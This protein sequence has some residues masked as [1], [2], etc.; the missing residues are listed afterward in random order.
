MTGSARYPDV[1]VVAPP[2]TPN[3][4]LHVGHLAGPYLGADVFTRFERIRGRD[5]VTALSTDEHQSYV[6]TTAA[7]LGRAPKDLAAAS[8]A[9]VQRTLT[10]AG[11]TFDIVGRPDDAYADDVTQWLQRLLEVGVFVERETDSLFDPATGRQLVESY[12]GGRCP[13]CLQATRGNICESC[14]HPNDPVRLV[15]PS[16]DCT[17]HQPER[18][19][20]RALVLPLERYRARL[21]EHYRGRRTRPELA[22]LLDRLLSEPLPPFPVAYE[23]SWGL[24]VPGASTV[25][26]VWAEMYPGHL[27]WIERARAHTSTQSPAPAL[28]ETGSAPEYVQFIGFDNSFFYAVV[29]VALGMAARDA[30]LPAAPPPTIITNQFYLLDGAKFST[31]QGHVIWGSALLEEWEPD[32]VRLFLCLSSPETQESNFT[33]EAM[34]RE[35]ESVLIAPFARVSDS[36][37]QLVADDRVTERCEDPWIT[38]Q[39]TLLRR[40]E[41][42]FRPD[43]FSLRRAATTLVTYLDLLDAELAACCRQGKTCPAGALGFLATC[44]APLM[45]GFAARLAALSGVTGAPSWSADTVHRRELVKPI[46]AGLLTLRRSPAPEMETHHAT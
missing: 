11:I 25:F 31:S 8:H 16:G 41:E 35:L 17:E 15:R 44:A 14:G 5:V 10:R 4:D 40:M 21:A 1:V 9:D 13:V 26:N 28:W 46:P 7:R 34:D 3:G 38:W 36:W 19:S 27:H 18:R 12:V 33:V 30:G 45:P 29:H 22:A 39:R 24:P 23:S 42:C 6:V 37:N 43:T 32:P 2:P 20:T